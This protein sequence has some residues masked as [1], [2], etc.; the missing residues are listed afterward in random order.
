LDY[1]SVRE[2]SG[3]QL[4]NEI[5]INTAE[6]VLDPVFLL[7]ANHWETIKKDSYFTDRYILVYDF[8]ENQAIKEY[9]IQY[10]KKHNLKIYTI[11]KNRYGDKD[12][13][14]DGP[15][16]FLSLIL[17]ADFI[18][19]N[20]FHATAFSIIFEKPFAV[21]DRK[22]RINARIHNLIELFGLKQIN[23]NTDYAVIRVKVAQEIKKSKQYIDRVLRKEKC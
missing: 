4:L 18:V 21:F 7:D 9:A 5:G 15:E 13:Y 17:H 6:Q 16:G 12:F 2:S 20:S 19:S 10:A 3:I 14:D 23:E 8:D 11:F 22:E 1:I